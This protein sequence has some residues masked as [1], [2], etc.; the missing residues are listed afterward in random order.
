MK[1]LTTTIL[2]L[3]TLALVL[4]AAG[5]QAQTVYYWFELIT[6]PNQYDY[7]D[8]NFGTPTSGSLILGGVDC[9]WSWDG[10]GTMTC[11]LVGYCSADPND[12][13]PSFGFG[14]Q[15]DL[16]LSNEV[17]V[18][19]RN[20]SSGAIYFN[21]G[22]ENPGGATLFIDE[23]V[24]SNHS[25]SFTAPTY[26]WARTFVVPVAGETVDARVTITCGDPAVPSDDSTWG[27]VKALFR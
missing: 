7:V 15:G 24:T 12:Q 8:I 11:D 26:E 13:L 16:A 25:W 27:D 19:M 9:D 18:V 4:S 2:T 14:G 20:G 1:K 21:G 3:A 6:A 22:Y 5:A 23:T 10:Y 17:S